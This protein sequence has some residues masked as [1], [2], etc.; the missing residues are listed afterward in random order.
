MNFIHREARDF[1]TKSLTD[2]TGEKESRILIG[3]SIASIGFMLLQILLM[4]HG[5]D[6]GVFQTIA[7]AMQRG[8]TPY[9]DVWDIKP[10]GIFYHYYWARQLFGDSLHAIRILEAFGLIS[11]VIA[12]CILSKRHVGSW[13]AGILAGALALT[14]HVQM[15]FWNTAQSESFG[16]FY[17]VWGFVCAGYSPKSS[18]EQWKPRGVWFVGALLFT[19]AFFLKPTLAGGG[20][21]GLFVSLRINT[22]ITKKNG[23]SIEPLLFYSMGSAIGILINVA[24]IA[25]GGGLEAFIEIYK[26]Y[27]PNHAS[28]SFYQKTMDGYL[29]EFVHNWPPGSFW[30]EMSGIAGFVIK[31]PTKRPEKEGL[32][33]VLAV[34]VLLVI[35][36]LVQG[37]FYMYHYGAVPIVLSLPAAWGYWRFL[38]TRSYGPLTMAVLLGIYGASFWKPMIDRLYDRVE[39][40]LIPKHRVELNHYRLEVGRFG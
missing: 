31:R 30:I 16:T 12:F 20:L 17:L 4:Q 35:G 9:R 29:H 24:P 1:S 34:A 22:S 2:R 37:K 28:N 18:E 14:A 25:L 3:L 10:P 36:V 19:E 39:T 11:I 23:F 32:L 8:R 6:Q 40:V 26:E 15:G 7:E 5:W 13:Q 27:I 21:V 33:S 38:R